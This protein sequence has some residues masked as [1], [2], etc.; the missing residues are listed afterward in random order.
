MVLRDYAEQDPTIQ[1]F[2]PCV[3]GNC[4]FVFT[5]EDIKEIRDVLTAN[6]VSAMVRIVSRYVKY[7]CRVTCCTFFSLGRALA[8]RIRR[9]NVGQPEDM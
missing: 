6:R 3:R 2:I 8:I 7:R 9:L 1:S 4:G 5:N